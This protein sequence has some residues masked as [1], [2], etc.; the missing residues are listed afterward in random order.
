MVNIIID[1][2]KLAAAEGT[3]VLAAAREAGVAIPTLC[4]LQALRPIRACRLCIVE[5]QA[6]GLTKMVAASC[7]LLVAE[8]MEIVTNS[9]EI[10]K[11]RA[12]IAALLLAGLPDNEAIKALAASLGIFATPF[13]VARPDDCALCGICIQACQ[14]KIGVSALSFAAKDGKSVDVV[15]LD[16]DRCVGCG[17][18]ANICPAGTIAVRDQ[19]GKR[20][21]L[22]YGKLVNTLDLAFCQ[23]CAAFIATRKVIN[24]LQNRLK[25]HELTMNAAYCPVCAR[26]NNPAPRY[27][28]AVN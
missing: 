28:R 9:Q 12:D 25:E 5:V 3:T 16:A 4:S 14:Q 11:M 7:D 10:T 24:L 26:E 17:T 8:G 15:I 2:K 18:C 23:E 13:T 1:G 19:N 21:L 20:E 27:E 22:L 6:P